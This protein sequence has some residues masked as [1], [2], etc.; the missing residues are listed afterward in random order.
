[1]GLRPR[2]AQAAA[3]KPVLGPGPCRGSSG[4]AFP[5]LVAVSF[6]GCPATCPLKVPSA[7]ALLT[8]PRSPRTQAEL[9]GLPRGPRGHQQRLSMPGLATVFSFLTRNSSYHLPPNT[10]WASPLASSEDCGPCRGVSVGRCPSSGKCSW[11]PP[12]SAARRSPRLVHLW[13]VREPVLPHPGVFSS[14]WRTWRTFTLGT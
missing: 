11:L 5:P 13:E 6:R 10:W 2:G 12:G 3:G 9:R 8:F 4:R 1:M 7:T 14:V